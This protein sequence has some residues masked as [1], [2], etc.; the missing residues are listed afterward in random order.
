[1]NLRKTKVKVIVLMVLTL[2]IGVF[3]V[4]IYTSGN[5]YVEKNVQ[6]EETNIVEKSSKYY[7]LIDE[8]ELLLP[9][10]F[11]DK[12]ELDKYNEYKI[13]YSYNRCKR[14]DG[15]IVSLKRYGEQP[16]GR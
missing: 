8:R 1:M 4:G 14:N 2:F 13:K 6:I 3:L 11:H 9:K 12:I 10:E 5:V 7:L 16:W 15:E